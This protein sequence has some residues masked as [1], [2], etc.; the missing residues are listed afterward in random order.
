MQIK[1]ETRDYQVRGI[2]EKKYKDL[3][4]KAIDEGLSLNKLIV[5]ILVESVEQPK[6]KVKIGRLWCPK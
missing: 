3:Q 4:H 1:T 2:P 5:K 6:R